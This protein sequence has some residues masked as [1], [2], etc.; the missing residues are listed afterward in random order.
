MD[1]MKKL[2]AGVEEIRSVAQK[3][4]VWADDLEK[5]FGKDVPSEDT[6]PVAAAPESA[7]AANKPVTRAE[8]KSFLTTLCAKGCAAQVKALIASFGVSSLSGVPEESLDELFNAALLL[9]GEEDAG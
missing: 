9:G 5:S 6:V 7:P 4:L 8:V 3:L 1:K 2:R